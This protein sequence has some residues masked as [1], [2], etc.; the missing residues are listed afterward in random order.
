[1]GISK[2]AVI[3]PS[4]STVM[5]FSPPLHLADVGGMQARAVGQRLLAVALL[6]PVLPQFA[7]NG[8]CDHGPSL[9][10]RDY[11]YYLSP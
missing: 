5:F 6:L 7:A 4:V 3:L 2:A 8:L 10:E 1:M 11:K 9:R